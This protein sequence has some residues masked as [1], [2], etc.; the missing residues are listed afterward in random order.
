[1][2]MADAGEMFSQLFGGESFRNWVGEIALG[3][4]FQQGMLLQT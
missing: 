2:D 4:Q 3:K 1:M